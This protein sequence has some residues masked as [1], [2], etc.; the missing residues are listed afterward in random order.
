MAIVIVFILLTC[1]PI[2]PITFGKIAG[3]AFPLTEM[4]NALAGNILLSAKQHLW[5]NPHFGTQF[6]FSY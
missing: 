5:A 1:A 4:Q 3:K 6:K 2:G